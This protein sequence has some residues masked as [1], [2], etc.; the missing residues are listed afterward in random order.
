M[1]DP[2]VTPVIEDIPKILK[3][4][5]HSHEYAYNQYLKK[6]QA[7][8]AEYKRQKSAIEEA[9]RETKALCTHPVDR[10]SDGHLEVGPHEYL[11]Y[12]Y[13]HNCDSYTWMEER[14]EEDSDDC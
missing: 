6:L 10:V 5:E 13:C 4:L 14:D 2:I 11:G 9:I 3:V 7:I 1:P 8:D 12:M